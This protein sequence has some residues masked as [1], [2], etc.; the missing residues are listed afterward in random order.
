MTSRAPRAVLFDLF[1]TLVEV[2]RNQLPEIEVAG[3]RVP[4]TLPR[5]AGLLDSYVGPRTPDDVL[6][7]FRTARPVADDPTIERPSRRRFRDLLVRLGCDDAA[8]EEAAVVLSRAHLAVIVEATVVPPS[9]RA[10][11]DAARSVGRVGIVSN[12]DD[13]AAAYAILA[14]HGLI[15]RVDAIVVSEAVGRRKPHPLPIVAALRSLDVSPRAAVFVGDGATADVG[16]ARAA[17]VPVVLV[18]RDGAASE[19]PADVLVVR[20]LT[21]VPRALGW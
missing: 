20:R 4:S 19:T 2:D 17:G 21:D 15:D 12:F 5:W 11:L 6:D 1:G 10:V 13:T 9:H 7:A 16:A 3:A 18:A 8:V 14:R